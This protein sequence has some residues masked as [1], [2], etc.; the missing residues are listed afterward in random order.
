DEEVDAETNVDFSCF[1]KLRISKSSFLICNVTTQRPQNSWQYQLRVCQVDNSANISKC[2]DM[3]KEQGVY[4]VPSP[5]DTYNVCLTKPG[6][7]DSCR[8]YQA[9]D[10][11]Q[12]DTPTNINAIY[13]KPEREYR[14]SYEYNDPEYLA[15][16]L[17][18]QISLRRENVEWPEC[19]SS[20]SAATG[21]KCTKTTLNSVNIPERNLASSATYE[22]RVRVQPNGDFYSGPWSP[23]S[24]T[25]SFNTG[26]IKNLPTATGVKTPVMILVVLS[27]CLCLAGFFII[28][29]F[30][31]SR[32]KPI[33]WP[34]IPNH[35][36]T[37]EK[38][39][40]KPRERHHITFNPSLFEDIPIN[41]V[42]DI[43]AKEH[44]DDCFSASH[45]VKNIT[46]SK[47]DGKGEE[48]RILLDNRG[49]LPYVD[50]EALSRFGSVLHNG[51]VNITVSNGMHS[52]CLQGTTTLTQNVSSPSC[53]GFFFNKNEP[54]NPLTMLSFGLPNYVNEEKPT[55]S[56]YR[57]E[58]YISM[59]A[60][61][62]PGSIVAANAHC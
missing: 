40:K 61:K 12:P 56:L 16:N 36:I 22:V 4:F 8:Y 62:T 57:E 9:K 49:Q 1:T 48:N 17:L 45:K 47:Q 51:L 44:E 28:T 5:M 60:F 3:K 19:D 37:L 52:N 20:P 35:K 14:I 32:I 31:K 23:W 10:I 15:K 50:I 46:C 58:A 41:K 34:E 29:L 24:E 21:P 42:D 38:I 43:K 25:A 39:C 11:V 26:F 59:S 27:F 13:D 33:V 30:W 54:S 7:N 18:F 6:M 55:M 2:I 53:G